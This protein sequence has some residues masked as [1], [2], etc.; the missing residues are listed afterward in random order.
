MH[1]L[2]RPGEITSLSRGDLAAILR[3]DRAAR[4]GVHHHSS[5][6]AAYRATRSASRRG[7]A[8][9]R[10]VA[11]GMAALVAALT[12]TGEAASATT[13]RTVK[14][15]SPAGGP[16]G[17][18]D[19]SHPVIASA[20]PTVVAFQSK[21]SN[22]VTPDADGTS[23]VFVNDTG[24]LTRLSGT[25]TPFTKA[26]DA[27]RPSI[28]A[29]GK[30]VAFL[31]K[32]TSAAVPEATNRIFVADRNAGT[33]KPLL[34][35]GGLIDEQ[36]PS[37]SPD[38]GFVAFVAHAS[39][40]VPLQVY[41]A[42]VTSGAPTLVSTVGPT[43]GN[44]A[45]VEPA[46]GGSGVAVAFSSLATNLA[47]SPSDTNAASDVFV[48]TDPLSATP[49][50]A[51]VSV[52]ASAEGN[53]PSFTPA[54]S[55]DGTK[56]V[57]RSYASNLVNGDLNG[58]ADIFL[59]DL[60]SG[61]TTLASQVSGSQG[62]GSS[63]QPS[64]TADGRYVG[65][66][67][68]SDNLVM[69]DTNAVS[70]VGHTP[71]NFAVF[72]ASGLMTYA[73]SAT[74][75]GGGTS[76]DVTVPPAA[77]AGAVGATVN[78]GAVID[79]QV[80][81]MAG[82]YGRSNANP[83]GTVA[84][85]PGAPTAPHAVTSGPDLV[86]VALA[87]NSA[88]FCFDATVALDDATGFVLQGYN[89]DVRLASTAAS[90]AADTHCVTATFTAPDISQI[91]DGIV[92]AATVHN[93]TGTAVAN[94]AD[95]RAV[96][97]AP[98]PAT[99]R[100]TAPD[101]VS[102][103]PSGTN[104]IDF[105]FD[106]GVASVT[107]ATRFG[108]ADSVGND[109]DAAS[110]V[111]QTATTVRAH[112]AAAVPAT[113][114]RSFAQNGAVKDAYGEDNPTEAI[115][116]ATT[117]PELVSVA[118]APSSP[119]TYA[120]TFSSAVKNPVAAS[121]HLFAEDGTLF[122]PAFV[123]VSALDSNTVLAFFDPPV[124]TLA[125]PPTVAG[126]LTGAAVSSAGALASGTGS[127]AT[128]AIGQAPGLTDGPDLQTA[129]FTTTPGTVR[130]T[131]D[132]PVQS[133][134]LSPPRGARPGVACA[135]PCPPIEQAIDRDAFVHDLAGGGTLRASVAEDGLQRT[136]DSAESSVSADGRFAVFSSL[137]PLT[138]G[139]SGSPRD[140]FV[141]DLLEA[142]V[143]PQTLQFADPTAHA[144]HI[145]A[146]SSSPGV[147]T[148]TNSG[149]GQLVV[150]DLQITGPAAGDYQITNETCRANSLGP[151]AACQ[152]T[153]VFTARA[154][155]VRTAFLNVIDN[156]S[157]SPQQITLQGQGTAP[158]TTAP[159]QNPFPSTTSTTGQSRGGTSGGSGATG[160]G[161]NSSGSGSSV[162]ATTAAPPPAPLPV[163][164]PKMTV[165]PA[166]GPVGSV[167]EATGSGFPPNTD[168]KLLWSR[169]IGSSTA[170]TDGAGSLRAPVLVFDNDVTGPRIL[171][172]ET[173]NVLGTAVFLALPG[174]D[175]NL[176]VFDRR[177]HGHVS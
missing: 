41:L 172:G 33:T 67:S 162:T 40:L 61:S 135:A 4:S 127:V 20:A 63:S 73:T 60:T 87:A 173:P 22:L 168:V 43:A 156:A 112:F 133:L 49:H 142:T 83:V 80:V 30:T 109:V 171:Y 32:V 28:S 91:T 77:I 45:S 149:F 94:I 84:K 72:D 38:G 46:V 47:S 107:N 68:T 64:V 14:L 8:A 155:G 105:V 116:G 35:S 12:L 158:P 52:G 160:G 119:T 25:L 143:T 82:P 36:Q 166:I 132:E 18:D 1:R 58:A 26:G 154:T 163:F 111:A 90:L 71:N 108:Y 92:L 122:V 48:V 93:D 101:L 86:S 27:V 146:A 157:T 123:S 24:A 78:E 150:T 34:T 167:V 5:R 74:V 174:G 152:V 21:A 169:G 81:P 103:T 102:A 10:T 131:F 100:T 115:G 153:M 42:P 175:S 66:T 23:D 120:Y 62:D 145:G 110:A 57:F 15:S 70:P 53:G 129:D 9:V 151:S 85:V 29:D 51:R 95:V 98:V 54:L 121:F 16:S 113:R 13:A 106:E 2:V 17:N 39:A 161:S 114:T 88:Q 104:D 11:V 97:A 125:L 124:G 96:G 37:I 140:V 69:G 130:F 117:Q 144:A 126:V 139:D 31:V 76:V 99:G 6:V 141:R 137:A 89:S 165:E 118:P 55:D 134:Q 164:N 159:P 176:F 128:A 147:A 19:S 44:G 170:R 56:V 136:G 79:S 3:G 75:S 138:S 50:L 59:R 148:V 7:V 65:F 177:R